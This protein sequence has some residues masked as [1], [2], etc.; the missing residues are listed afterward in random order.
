MVDVRL[1]VLDPAGLHQ[2]P[3]AVFVRTAS[4]FASRVSI[5]AGE[6]E[7]DAKS[8]LALM[9]LTI[10]PRAE[11]TLRADGPDEAAALAALLEA[12]GSSVQVAGVDG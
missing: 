11:I 7:A 8:L 4:Q 5:R 3:A 2:R 12:L 9:G 6:R 10:R 1:I